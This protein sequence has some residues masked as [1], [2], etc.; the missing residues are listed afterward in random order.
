MRKRAGIKLLAMI[1]SSKWVKRGWNGEFTPSARMSAICDP[2]CFVLGLKGSCGPSMAEKF[3]ALS[4]VCPKL[5]RED[6]RRDP[7]ARLIPHLWSRWPA[8]SA[9]YWAKPPGLSGSSKCEKAPG[10]FGFRG[11]ISWV[12]ACGSTLRPKARREG[13]NGFI[14]PLRAPSGAR[15]RIEHAHA[16]RAR[17]VGKETR[18]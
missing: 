12:S 16:Q 5:L 13:P 2:T 3:S 7:V 1:P 4:Y 17:R 10:I 14:R 15:G 11:L 9:L 18:G 6:T 8:A